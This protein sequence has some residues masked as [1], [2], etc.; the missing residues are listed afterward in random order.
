[1]GFRSPRTLDEVPEQRSRGHR[2]WDARG[3][4]DRF[5]LAR[6]AFPA[7][8]R[9]GAA[10]ARSSAT[11][12]L[13][14]RESAFR[15]PAA[16]TAR[17]CVLQQDIAPPAGGPDPNPRR[18]TTM[19]IPDRPP[20]YSRSRGRRR[21]M[22]RSVSRMRSLPAMGH[23]AK[24]GVQQRRPPAGGPDPNPKADKMIIPDRIF[25]LAGAT[26]SAASIT[27]TVLSARCVYLSVV[28][29]FR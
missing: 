6:M 25:P 16:R 8:L 28:S 12:D 5:G 14:P 19:I 10:G 11:P 24:R 9:D 27:V 1:M 3:R 22:A 20:P 13:R 15:L 26:V 21:A 17:R 23:W 7:D 29:G 18:P 4:S 2:A